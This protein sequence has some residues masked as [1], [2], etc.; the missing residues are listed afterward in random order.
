MPVPR[1]RISQPSLYR[2]VGQNMY[3]ILIDLVKGEIPSSDHGD[4]HPQCPWIYTADLQTLSSGRNS[5]NF[6][7]TKPLSKF[8]GAASSYLSK[9]RQS[10]RR[11]FLKTLKERDNLENRASDGR[12]ISKEH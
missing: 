7:N 1:P 2:S 6:I 12:I 9:L 4:Q 10:T 5:T 11:L 3:A 8:A